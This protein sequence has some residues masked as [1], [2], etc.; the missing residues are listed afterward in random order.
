MGRVASIAR[1]KVSCGLL[2]MA[3]TVSCS[4]SDPVSGSIVIQG[5]STLFPLTGEVA[6]VFNRSQPDVEVTMGIAGTGGGFARFCD[7]KTDIQDAS[8]PINPE[9]RRACS[10]RN[11]QYIE[12]PIAYD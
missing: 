6:R 11:V 12:L 7:G 1:H 8:R 10:A 2:L 3:I 9:E 4:G 5:S